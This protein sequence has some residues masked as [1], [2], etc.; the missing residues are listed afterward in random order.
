MSTAS[1][2]T[3]RWQRI[4]GQVRGNPAVT[5][6]QLYAQGRDGRIWTAERR[7]RLPSSTWSGWTPLPN[8][9]GGTDFYAE[10]GTSQYDTDLLYVR[11]NDG[12][13]WRY[14]T[15]FIPNWVP[16]GGRFTSGFSGI[17]QIN[18]PLGDVWVYGRGTNG[19]LYYRTL[20]RFTG[21]HLL[22]T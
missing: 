18:G 4:G 9:P 16:L 7:D 1:G 13:C 8:S 6:T 19:K 3:A 5:D 21:W 17:H 14:T 12:T 20:A 22:G 15:A 11:G 2:W 10:P